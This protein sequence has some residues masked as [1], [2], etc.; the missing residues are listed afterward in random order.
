MTEVE[1]KRMSR[2]NLIEIIYQYQSREQKYAQ[3]IE[4]LTKQ[5]E[6]RRIKLEKTGSIAEAAMSLNHVFETA[7]AAAD[8][9][10]A[11]IHEMNIHKEAEVQKILSE[12]RAEAEAIRQKAQNEYDATLEKAKAECDAMYNKITEL[13][14][15]YEELRGLLQEQV[16]TNQ[17]QV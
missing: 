15:N 17:E 1:L 4:E 5:V 13:L 10:L 8:Q 7:Q 16:A 6:D 14:K 11:E 2:G 9:Y 12:A 3:K